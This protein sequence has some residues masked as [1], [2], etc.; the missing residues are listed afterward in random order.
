MLCD[1]VTGSH[2]ASFPLPRTV[3]WPSR[4]PRPRRRRPPLFKSVEPPLPIIRTLRL[5]GFSPFL[6][7]CYFHSA[8]FP[9][10]LFSFVLFV[11]VPLAFA[12]SFAYVLASTPLI[13]PVP[14]F[15]PRSPWLFSLHKTGTF[16]HLC[17]LWIPLRPLINLLPGSS[18]PL[19]QLLST[20]PP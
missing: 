1:R 12:S 14:F 4:R 18:T 19:L 3:G 6:P 13:R 8:T 20:T 5:V 11:P 17:K 9:P 2:P 10:Q 15:L 7:A 16:H